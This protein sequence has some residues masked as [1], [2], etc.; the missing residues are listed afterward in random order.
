VAWRGVA[1]RGWDAAALHVG[2][3]VSDW[4][5]VWGEEPRHARAVEER[6][7]GRMEAPL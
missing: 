2:A 6:G 5:G 3:L 7:A 4:C 1:W